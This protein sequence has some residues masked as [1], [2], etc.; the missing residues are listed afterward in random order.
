MD[1]TKPLTILAIPG[2]LRARSLNR[3]ALRAAQ[4]LTPPGVTLE[5]VEL[6]DIPLYN[7]DIDNDGGPAPVRAFKQRITAADGLLIATPEY[8]Y[9]IPGVLKNA[10][11]WASRPAYKSP[12]AGKPVAMFGAAG[13]FVG[14]A[15]ALSQSQRP[16]RHCSASLSRAARR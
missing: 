3:A 4:T 9:S 8:N 10:I 6:A 14:G 16:A 5:L 2:S 1:A 7:G 11:D 13:G 15:R 12:L